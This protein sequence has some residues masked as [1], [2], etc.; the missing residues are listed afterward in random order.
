MGLTGLL[1]V[2][3]NGLVTHQTSLQT[4]G[5]NVSNVNTRGYSRQDTITHARI[6]TPMS[7][8]FIGNGVVAT[9][10][11][12]D[13]DQFITK[14]LFEK[15]SDMT[16]LNTRQSG[17]KLIESVMNEVEENGL[18]ELINEFWTAWDDVAN[19]AEGMPERTTLLQRA[20]LLVKEIGGKYQQLVQISKNVDLNIDTDIKA[21]NRLAEQVAEINV[22]I[23]SSEAGAHSANDLRDQRDMLIKRMSELA[24]IHYFET[25]RGSY[26]VLIGQGSPLVDG[27][28]SWNL[29]MRS[30]EIYWTGNAGQELKLTKKDI[31]GGELGGWIDMKSRVTPRDPTI[32][33]GSVTNASGGRAIRS[34]TRWD[35]IDGVTVT[36]DFNIVF[37][38]TDQN[39]NSIGPVNFSYT[40]AS[41]TNPQV[42]DFLNAIE[43]AFPN[44]EAS[45]TAD[46]RIRI[47][48]LVPGD[49][50]VSFQ[51]EDINGGITGLDLGKFDGDYPLN[52]TEQLN[53]WASELIKAVN[54]V[55]SQG[56]GLIPLQESTGGYGVIDTS[57]AIS[58]RASGLAFS[59]VVQTGSFEIYL[60][61]SSGDVI[62][63]NPGTD[64]NEPFRVN[65]T[66]GVTSLADIR[67]AINAPAPPAG[68]GIPGLTAR[69]V[70]NRLVIG[71]DGSAAAAGFAFGKDSSGALTALG[72]ISFFT[73]EDASTIG[74]NSRLM[75]DPRL[76]AA[77]QV[78]QYGAASVLSDQSVMDES[79]A[80][81][82]AIASGTVQVQLIDSAGTAVQTL[83]ITIDRNNDSID[84][85]LNQID[86]VDGMHAWVENDL[87]HIEAEN[88]GYSVSVD[89]TV[90]GSDITFVEFLGLSAGPAARLDGTL[91]VERTFE[92]INSY[93]TGVTAGTFAIDVMDADGNIL[94]PPVPSVVIN[95]AASDT[96]SDIAHAIDTNNNISAEVVNGR[97]MITA[98]G[99]GVAVFDGV[100]RF[101]SITG[102]RSNFI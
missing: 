33:T 56:V 54:G 64:I 32:L 88:E 27:P 21:L 85:V 90:G 18:N 49:V 39:G 29:E 81:G 73:G 7:A 63:A 4:I 52:Y 89:D 17:M 99:N 69:I 65:I 79:R 98:E 60:Y 15:T 14:S 80:V 1:N 92:A 84:D 3:K 50:P 6:P 70:N 91:R 10:I 51:I 59:D 44:V 82:A 40:Q 53:K 72:L 102:S 77:A 24:D 101:A 47:E 45:I 43:A 74:I 57:R 37:S 11:L 38:G 87:V 78:E 76:I 34:S 9:E 30:G 95:V 19:L 13:Y 28:E 46:G 96:L 16:G 41:D 67:D 94:N 12:R 61:D 62:D 83:T 58:S 93:D 68:S 100:T 25:E 36:G 42:D 20:E 71:V 26:T 23:V 31:Q 8:G 35:A 86:G 5:H 22:Q 2:A 48:D 75:E 66:R 55:H 97:L